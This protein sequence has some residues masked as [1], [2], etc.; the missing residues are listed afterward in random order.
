MR[1]HIYVVNRSTCAQLFSVSDTLTVV[2][3]HHLCLVPK[4]FLPRRTLHLLSVT[5]R[6]TPLPQEPLPVPEASRPWTFPVRGVPR[7]TLS[8]IS[9]GAPATEH[10]STLHY[11]LWLTFMLIFKMLHSNTIL[12]LFICD[13]DFLHPRWVP[14][15]LYPTSIL[16]IAEMDIQWALGKMPVMAKSQ[17][18]GQIQEAELSPAT[19]VSNLG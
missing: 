4:H 6:P 14:Q 7:V 12:L 5:P 8:R 3:R 11:F 18:P 19:H 15:S 1:V 16:A 10:V 17:R 13:W 2:C 9:P